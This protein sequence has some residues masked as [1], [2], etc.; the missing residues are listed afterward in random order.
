MNVI[1]Q[2]VFYYALLLVAK[3]YQF[4]IVTGYHAVTI[5]NRSS[6]SADKEASVF[7]RYKCRICK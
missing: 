7:L 2:V 3:G 4:E 6:L 5:Y 1:F